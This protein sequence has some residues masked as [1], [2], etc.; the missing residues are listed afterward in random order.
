MEIRKNGC[1]DEKM[2]VG[3][4]KKWKMKME[5]EDEKMEDGNE[6]WRLEVRDEEK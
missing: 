3:D 5:I 1:G 2:E 4:G 6:K